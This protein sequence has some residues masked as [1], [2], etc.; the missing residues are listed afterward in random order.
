MR[1]TF[2]ARLLFVHK[3]LFTAILTN[4]LN[5]VADILMMERQ[6]RDNHDRCR[7]SA[8]IFAGVCNYVPGGVNSPVKAHGRDDIEKNI[9][10]QAVRE[11][12]LLNFLRCGKNFL[13]SQPRQD[14]I[15]EK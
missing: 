10:V 5:F 15:S 4:G 13:H 11:P 9:E 8:E 2:P 12:T 7:E 6:M 3:G 1:L 14:I